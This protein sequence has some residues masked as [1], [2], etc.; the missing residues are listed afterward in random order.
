MIH[1]CQ[2]AD[3]TDELVQECGLQQVCLL[4]DE[5]LVGQHHLLCSRRVR[6]QK[7]PVDEA[8]V[9]EWGEK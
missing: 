4:G 3:V 8:A 2:R 1:R 5:G 9:P 6:G 7:T